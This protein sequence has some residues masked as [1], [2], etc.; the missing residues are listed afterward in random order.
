MGLNTKLK[1]AAAVTR[2]VGVDANSGDSNKRGLAPYFGA[3]LRGLIRREMSDEM[4]A[5]FA[6]RGMK[7]TLC[8]SEDGILYWAPEYVDSFGD[9]RIT[10]LAYDLLHEVMHVVLRHLERTRALGIVPEPTE[11]YFAKA[12]LANLASDACANEELEKMIVASGNKPPTDWVTPATLKQP[13]GLVFEERYRLL[14]KEAEKQQQSGDQNGG[15]SGSKKMKPKPGHGWCGGCAGHPQPGEPQGKTP[16]GRSQAE[17]DR[18]RREV[19]NA[20]KDTASRN[21]GLVPD[22]LVRWADEEL[23]PPKIPWQEK[24]SRVIRGAVARRAGHADLTWGRPSRRQGGVGYGIGR[25]V[26]PSLY[27]PTPE[28]AFATDTSG[29]MGAA[30]LSAALAEVNGVLKAT[31][32]NITFLSCDAEVHGITKIKSVQEAMKLLKGGGGTILEPAVKA[33]SELKPQPSI[34]I[35]ATDGYCDDPPNYG[36]DLIFVVVGGN[37]AYK[38]THGEVVYADD[39]AA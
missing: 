22:S 32:A 25:P 13:L 8:V 37:R 23:A 34:A 3:A 21:R 28:V 35:V 33:M 14:L 6:M 19:A 24:L 39:E 7:P 18:F 4:R 27:A 38:P 20:V 2:V 1:M 10:Y 12:T 26:M 31:G 15:G 5:V 16:E 17:M 36:L 30:E 9:D 11:E 29:S